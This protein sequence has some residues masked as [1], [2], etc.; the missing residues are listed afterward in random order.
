MK[1]MID[2]EILLLV[3]VNGEERW[4]PQIVI[5]W[6]EG[7]EYFMVRYDGEIVELPLSAEGETWKRP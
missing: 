4:V 2:T 6:E 5:E 7:S 1:P 3:D